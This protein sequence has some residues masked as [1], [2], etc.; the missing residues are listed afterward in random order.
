[1]RVFSVINLSYFPAA[2]ECYF[3]FPALLLARAA[4]I[5]GYDDAR[6]ITFSYGMVA[7]FLRVSAVFML[8]GDLSTAF[9]E[10]LRVISFLLYT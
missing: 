6:V 5:N 7:V 4:I 1:M 8:S 2:A 10:T 9:P 3:L